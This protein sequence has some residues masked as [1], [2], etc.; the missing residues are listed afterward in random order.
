MSELPVVRIELT[1]DLRAIALDHVRSYLGGDERL[2]QAL[3]KWHTGDYLSTSFR[4]EADMIVVIAGA[5]RAR[6]YQH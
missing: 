1:D 5:L 2:E 3:R 4:I 6:A